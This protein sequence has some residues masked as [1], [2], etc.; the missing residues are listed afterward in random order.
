MTPWPVLTPPRWYRRPLPL[1]LPCQVLCDRDPGEAI[2]ALEVGGQNIQAIVRRWAV[3]QEGDRTTLQAA[4]LGE[5]QE[6]GE[7]LALVDIPGESPTAG[8]R[9]KFPRRELEPLLPHTD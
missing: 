6:E 4:A 9:L 1:A 3:R 2:V 8:S 7:T 5:F